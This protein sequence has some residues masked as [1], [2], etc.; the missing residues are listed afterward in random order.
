MI[1]G[2]RAWR[3]EEALRCGSRPGCPSGSEVHPPLEPA[4]SPSAL[5]TATP[6]ASAKVK[7]WVDYFEATFR[8]HPWPRSQEI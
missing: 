4:R 8:D 3:Q 2:S 5:S 1:L 6:R 7:A